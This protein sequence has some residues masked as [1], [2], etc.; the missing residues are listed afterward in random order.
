MTK[1][2][3]LFLASAVTFFLSCSTDENSNETSFETENIEV[4]SITVDNDSEGNHASENT[5][6]YG[7]ITYQHN[8]DG[9]VT[10]TQ[11]G[12][13]TYTIINESVKNASIEIRREK[14]SNAIQE[15]IITNSITGEFV[16]LINVKEHKGYYTFDMVNDLG[17]SI[18][19]M[20]FE[21]DL[22]QV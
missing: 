16:K 9:N 10:R 17:N 7:D 15:Y 19:N 21:G 3:C 22:T 5:L 14:G 6:R 2:K 8:N 13:K 1:F 12:Q 20:I 11:S 4:I 18:E